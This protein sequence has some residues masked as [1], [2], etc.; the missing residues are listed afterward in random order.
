MSRFTAD[1]TAER[2]YSMVRQSNCHTTVRHLVRKDVSGWFRPHPVSETISARPKS[3]YLLSPYRIATAPERNSCRLTSFKSTGFDSPANNVGPWPASLGCTTNS[4]SSINPSSANA[5]GSVT[6]PTNSPLPAPA[7]RLSCSTDLAKSPHTSS[8]FQSTRSSVLDTT[9][10][11]AASIVR[12]KRS[13][14][15]GL[16]PAGAGDRHPASIISYVT[17]PK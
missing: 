3:L 9:Y 10:F 4:K 2:G 7:P 6:P 12:A 11:L 15:S 17:R 14:H 5:S 8:A 16:V 1:S 13:I